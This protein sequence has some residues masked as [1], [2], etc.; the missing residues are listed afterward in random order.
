MGARIVTLNCWNV[1]EPLV[2]R[3]AVIR[4]G[5]AALA[6][7]VVAFQEIVVRDD[8]FDQ[9]ALL[10]D[11]ARYFRVFGPAFRWDG[12]GGMLPHDGDGGGFGN[13][14]ASVWPIVRSEVR[15]LPGGDGDEPRTAIGAL[16][17]TPAGVLPVVTTHLDW[18]RD[19]GW[20]RERQVVALDRFAREWARGGDLPPILLGDFNARPDATEMRYLRGLASLEGRSTYWQDA[21]EMA[22]SPH[23]G[24]TW[25]NRNRF[26][27]YAGEPNERI[28]YILVGH[29]DDLGRGR[30]ETAGLAFEEPSVGVYASDHFGVVADV[31]M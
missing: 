8:G 19:H 16:L 6:P 24:F 22:G 12:D 7:E 13:L 26:A 31:R 17:E 29:P 15:R 25:D 2:E 11:A 20:V 28:D 9:G 14:I 18:E 5:L 3:A 21:W 1:S 30:I 10:L 27:S 4:A 23:P